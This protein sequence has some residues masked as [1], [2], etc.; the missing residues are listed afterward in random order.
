MIPGRQSV[1]QSSARSCGFGAHFV[2]YLATEVGRKIDSISVMGGGALQA[3][4]SLRIRNDKMA[5]KKAVV[6]LIAAQ[7]LRPSDRWAPMTMFR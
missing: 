7:S 5:G 4:N 6:W 3:R 2:A 1:A